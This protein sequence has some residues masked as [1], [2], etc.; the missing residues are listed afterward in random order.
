MAATLKDIEATLKA[1]KNEL[2]M[3]YHVS[4][5]GIFGSYAKGEQRGKSDVDI[6]VELEK[7]TFDHYMDL[8]FFLEDLLGRSVDLVLADSVKPRLK[9]LVT[10]ETVYV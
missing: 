8:Q 10:E 1:H 3:D 5:L 6:L 2:S 7:P 4:E 9:A